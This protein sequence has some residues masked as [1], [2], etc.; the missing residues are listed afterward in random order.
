MIAINVITVRREHKMW[1]PA[2]VSDPPDLQTWFIQ[3]QNHLRNYQ[4]VI[5][6]TGRNWVK[7]SI[8]SIRVSDATIA[9]PKEKSFKF[10]LVTK[11]LEAGEW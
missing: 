11:I 5:S 2:V 9:T 10:S 4:L 6:Q 7:I 1:H 3:S 8:D